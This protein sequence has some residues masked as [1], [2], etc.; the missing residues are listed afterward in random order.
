MFPEGNDDI[1]TDES[2]KAFWLSYYESYNYRSSMYH[3]DRQLLEQFLDWV[4][5]I[6][7]EVDV[8]LDFGNLCAQP[9]FE[10]AK[11]FPNIK[12]IGADRQEF[13]AKLN[14]NAYESKNL[15]LNMVIY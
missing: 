8:V 13:I 9:L 11:L 4:K 12:F 3:G 5:S 10:A 6:S 2:C 14:R 1:Y 15:S 7:N